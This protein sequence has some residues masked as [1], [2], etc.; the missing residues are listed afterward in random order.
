MGEGIKEEGEVLTGGR[1][2]GDEKRGRKRGMK[3]THRD[4]K[5]RGTER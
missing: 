5:G 3:K 1:E 2:K 4:G